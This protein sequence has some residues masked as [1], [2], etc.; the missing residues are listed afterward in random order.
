VAREKLGRVNF[1]ADKSTDNVQI[2]I[3]TT[4]AKNKNKNLTGFEI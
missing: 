3:K 1:Y 4:F 2:F